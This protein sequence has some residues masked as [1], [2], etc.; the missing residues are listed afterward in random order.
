MNLSVSDREPEDVFG[1]EF[2]SLYGQ[3]DGIGHPQVFSNFPR[4][5]RLAKAVVG[6]RLRRLQRVAHGGI[7]ESGKNLRGVNDRVR[8]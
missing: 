3:G 1:Y 8:A 2:G 6:D 5:D 4:S 7:G